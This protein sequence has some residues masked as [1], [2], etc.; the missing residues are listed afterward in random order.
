M[1]YVA[2][3]VY[4]VIHTEYDVGS[5]CSK[6]KH[7]LT[8]TENKHVFTVVAEPFRGGLRASWNDDDTHT[9]TFHCTFLIHRKIVNFWSKQQ[10]QLWLLCALTMQNFIWKWFCFVYPH[11]AMLAGASCKLYTVF[12]IAVTYSYTVWCVYL[13]FLKRTGVEL[14]LDTWHMAWL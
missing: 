3:F 12:C 7:K 8:L 14:E 4:S 10:I 13:K 1:I 9:A 2:E 11:N 6:K 5:I